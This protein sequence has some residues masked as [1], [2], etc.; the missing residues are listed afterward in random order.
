M[1]IFERLSGVFEA[2]EVGHGQGM[3]SAGVRGPYA[4]STTAS[5]KDVGIW[6]R[7]RLTVMC[8][9]LVLLSSVVCLRSRNPLFFRL[10]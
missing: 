6:Q 4:W 3:H 1:F 5:G 2:N 7:F 10:D 8:L 9:R